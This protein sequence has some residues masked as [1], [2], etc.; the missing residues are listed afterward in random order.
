MTP[1][2]RPHGAAIGPKTRVIHEIFRSRIIA[3]L[4]SERADFLESAAR[5][6]VESGIVVV[7]FALTTPTALRVLEAFSENAP[8]G[9]CVGAGTVLGASDANAAIAAGARY[10]VTPAVMPDVLS[11][12]GKHEVPVITGALTP[13]EVVT[14][15]DAGSA[16]VKIFPAALGGPRYVRLLRDPLPQ[17]SLVPTGGIGLDEVVE[18]LRAGSMAVGMGNSLVGEALRGGDLGLLRSRAKALTRIIASIGEPA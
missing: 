14:A 15:H 10:L 18:Y 17:I 1:S 11:V 2:H 5:T 3:V 8:P 6:L 7:E 9:A 12:A 13:T 4:R 16:A